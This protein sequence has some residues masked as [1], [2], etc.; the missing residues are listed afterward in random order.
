[1]PKPLTQRQRNAIRYAL[2]D[3]GVPETIA[4]MAARNA[5]NPYAAGDKYPISGL[6]LWH[7]TPEGH[8]FWRDVACEMGDPLFP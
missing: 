7:E 4:F 5:I 1:M 8:E 2:E 6:F 3:L